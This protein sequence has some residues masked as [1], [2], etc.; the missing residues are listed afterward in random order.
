MV[1]EAAAT[2]AA[3]V[4]FEAATVVAA[5]MVSVVHSIITTANRLLSAVVGAKVTA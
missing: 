5:S 3:D 1:A 4:T 2:A